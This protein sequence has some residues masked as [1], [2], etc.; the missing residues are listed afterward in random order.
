MHTNLGATDAKATFPKQQFHPSWK[1]L[2]GSPW[3]VL[4]NGHVQGEGCGHCFPHLGTSGLDARVPGFQQAP[5]RAVQGDSCFVRPYL[6]PNRETDPTNIL[7]L[8]PPNLC[9]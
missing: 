2:S 1:G 7:A 5:E 8:S 6:A 3:L 4:E 9:W